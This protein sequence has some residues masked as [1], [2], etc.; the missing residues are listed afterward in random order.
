[1]YAYALLEWRWD[2][3]SILCRDWS[4][5]EDDM[6]VFLTTIVMYAW[7]QVV[8]LTYYLLK[9]N[10]FFVAWSSVRRNIRVSKL[11]SSG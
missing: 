4:S 7:R 11:L 3:E 1:M 5:V 9:S 8:L 10:T 6:F 2:W